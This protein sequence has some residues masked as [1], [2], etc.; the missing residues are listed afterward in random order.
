MEN[1][2]SYLLKMV[3]QLKHGDKSEGANGIKNSS[4]DFVGVGDDYSMSFDF[5]DVVDFAVDGAHISATEKQP[6]GN[7]R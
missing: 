7:N 1:E 2:P 4:Q 3:Q 6:N 5:K